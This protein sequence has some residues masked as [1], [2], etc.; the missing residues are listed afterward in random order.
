MATAGEEGSGS[1][2]LSL[3]WIE[4]SCFWVN[5]ITLVLVL[6]RLIRLAKARRTN[7]AKSLMPAHS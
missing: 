7:I 5:G 6:S 4:F 2:S 1:S 3:A